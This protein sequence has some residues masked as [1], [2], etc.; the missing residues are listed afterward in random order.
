MSLVHIPLF[1]FLI[2]GLAASL[3]RRSLLSFPGGLC[4]YFLTLSQTFAVDSRVYF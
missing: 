4:P 3:E 1:D 2:S